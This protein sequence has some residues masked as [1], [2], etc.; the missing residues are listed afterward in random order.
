VLAPVGHRLEQQVG[1]LRVVDVRL[2]V[3]E[4]VPAEPGAVTGRDVQAVFAVPLPVPRGCLDHGLYIGATNDAL[5]CCR[6][7]TRAR[8]PSR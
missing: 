7:L 2:A 6:A 3:G 8:L 5:N 1:A 4:V